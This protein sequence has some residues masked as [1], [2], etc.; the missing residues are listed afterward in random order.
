MEIRAK[1]TIFCEGA[2]GSLSEGLKKHFLLDKDAR[3]KQHYGIGLKEVWEVKDGNPHFKEGLV[4]HT[5]NWPV[6][7]DV[8]AG[9]FMYHMKPN[10]VL[11]GLVVGL[12]YKNPYLN[13]YE[14]FQ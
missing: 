5:V 7:N 14:E 9:S 11:L 2:R 12:D 6:T 4:Q 10:K 1:Q 3:S 8:Y 13:P